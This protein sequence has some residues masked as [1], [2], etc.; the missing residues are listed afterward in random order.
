MLREICVGYE[1]VRKE[2]SL[3]RTRRAVLIIIQPCVFIS[4]ERDETVEVQSGLDNKYPLRDVHVRIGLAA[5]PQ[6]CRNELRS[7]LLGCP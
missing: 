6:P 1:I 2:V 5:F 7:L 4:I 3:G